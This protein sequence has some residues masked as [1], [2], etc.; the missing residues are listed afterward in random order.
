[1]AA[2]CTSA[3]YAGCSG[4]SSSSKVARHP[5]ERRVGLT[6][7]G[8]IDPEV[9]DRGVT[10]RDEIG[11]G[12]LVALLGEVRRDVPAGLAAA[13]GEEDAHGSFLP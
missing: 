10:Q 4:R 12:D 1:M 8:E 11:V 7:I 3:S 2:K 5:G 9:G 6:G 13:A